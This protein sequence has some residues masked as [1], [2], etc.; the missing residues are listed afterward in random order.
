MFCVSVKIKLCVSLNCKGQ[1]YC[2]V[3]VFEKGRP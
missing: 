3:I 2:S 1:T